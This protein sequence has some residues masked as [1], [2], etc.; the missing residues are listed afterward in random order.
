VDENFKNEFRG[1]EY[2]ITK[3]ND[4]KLSEEINLDLDQ[5]DP[6]H[7]NSDVLRQMFN[8]NIED[9]YNKKKPDMGGF[10][11]NNGTEE[12]MQA[13]S[14]EQIPVLNGLAKIMPFQ[15][16]GFVPCQVVLL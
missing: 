7:D 10:A 1:K 9:Y 2:N 5:Q 13:Y 14:P 11:K 15:M 16:I 8:A 12:V 6:Y 3:Y 4:G